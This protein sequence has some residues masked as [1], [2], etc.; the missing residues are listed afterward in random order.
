NRLGASALMQGLADG[1][2]V[3]PYTIGDYLADEILTPKIDTNKP[4]FEEAEK[5]VTERIKKLFHIKGTKPVDYLHKKLEH[6]MRDYVGMSRNEEGLQKAIQMLR[7]I[8]EGFWKDVKIPGELD[9]LRP[10]LER[11]GRV[12]HFLDIGELMAMDALDRNE[13]GG[14]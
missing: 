10:E 6:R 5:A 8:R 13:S 1:Y 11:A 7:E 4:E 2:F 3:L 12:A 14:G 9:N